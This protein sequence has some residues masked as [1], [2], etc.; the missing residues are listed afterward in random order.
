VNLLW[1]ILIILILLALI[2][3]GIGYYR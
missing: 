2:G 1:L 3:G